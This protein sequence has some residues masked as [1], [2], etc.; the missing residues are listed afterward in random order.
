[1]ISPVSEDS[2]LITLGSGIDPA[3][4]G[5]IARLCDSL[6]DACAPWLLELIPSYTTVL[7]TYDL[8]QVDFREACRVIKTVTET[9]LAEGD[10]ATT[11]GQA[12]IELPVYYSRDTGP[13]LQVISEKTALTID[14]IIE[15]HTNRVYDVY[16]IGFAPGFAFM[17]KVDPDIALPRKQ[18]PRNRVP[19]GSVGI[20]NQ[21]T[22]VYP[23]E[24]PGGWQL[25]GRCPIILFDP[26]NLSRLK[27]GDK[28]RFVAVSRERFLELG[29]AL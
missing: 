18:S 19:A 23:L 28:V 7:V 1:M 10:V 17:G 6:S 4:P 16:A 29:G 13:D 20:A 27:V 11:S 8:M 2:V 25:I 24:S 5:R 12:V 21:Q 26:S 15:K 22:A 3:L 9:S 14:Q